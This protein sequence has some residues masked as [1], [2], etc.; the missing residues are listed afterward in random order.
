MALISL[1]SSERFYHAI[2]TQL[3]DIL[4]SRSEYSFSF[5]DFSLSLMLYASDRHLFPWGTQ[6]VQKT[7]NMRNQWLYHI[8]NSLPIPD[9]PV[10]L[11][12]TVPMTW[13]WSCSGH[14]GYVYRTSG[15]YVRTRPGKVG[16]LYTANLTETFRYWLCR[17]PC[18]VIFGV[19]AIV[20]QNQS[21]Y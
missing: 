18:V 8:Y 11:A 17:I 10:L 7:I 20:F 5:H 19:I 12:F 15:H 6:C 1:S 9:W 16:H 21:T 13:Q 14:R 4:K 3:A 2:Q